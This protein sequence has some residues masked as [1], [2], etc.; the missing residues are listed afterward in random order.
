MRFRA[1]VLST[2]FVSICSSVATA[3]NV[4]FGAFLTPAETGARGQG[5]A[6]IE[7][8]L[9]TKDMLVRAGFTNM[10]GNSTGA[11]LRGPTAEA[12]TGTADAILP[13]LV[14]FPTGAKTGT[15]EREYDMSLAS[16]YAASFLN[17]PTN[18]G[19]VSTAFNSL[20]TSLT[21]QKVY[22]NIHS[23]SY[24]NGEL[25]GFFKVVPPVPEPM[26]AAALAG[27]LI[28]VRRRR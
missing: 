25:R 4:K 7:F 10:R 26:G 1:L 20:I 2:A 19:D 6:S 9:N 21:A 16:N 14:A 13:A 5:W 28:V 8:D 17:N 3:S 22:L 23:T 12:T 11:T 18:G 24:Q 15:Y 27:L